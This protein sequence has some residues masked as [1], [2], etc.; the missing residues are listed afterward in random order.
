[1]NSLTTMQGKYEGVRTAETDDELMAV[2]PRRCCSGRAPFVLRLTTVLATVLLLVYFVIAAPMEQRSIQGDVPPFSPDFPG[3]DDNTT[4]QEGCSSRV[5]AQLYRWWTTH[6]RE[7]RRFFPRSNMPF[8]PIFYQY[9]YINETTKRRADFGGSV[10][11][12][13]PSMACPWY[14]DDS[15][16]ITLPDFLT[17]CKTSNKP[18]DPHFMA[19]FTIY[20]GGRAMGKLAWDHRP[21]SRVRKEEDVYGGQQQQQQVVLLKNIPLRMGKTSKA[22][23]RHKFYGDLVAFRH[24]YAPTYRV[25]PKLY[26]ADPESDSCWIVDCHGNVTECVEEAKIGLIELS[27]SD[28]V[29]NVKD[30]GCE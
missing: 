12:T 20:M 7:T 14:F 24:A 22:P 18:S 28:F 29:L 25:K 26:V 30:I 9:N 3:M 1:M 19:G 27:V 2:E 16:C 23:F 17:T 4:C 21:C 6:R 11:I 5:I 13:Y 10:E 15:P 8:T